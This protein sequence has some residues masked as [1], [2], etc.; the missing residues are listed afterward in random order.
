MNTKE[1][2]KQI[3]EFVG[4]QENIKNIMHCMTRLRIN[5]Y[6]NNKV[7]SEKLESLKDVLKVQF[8]NDQL[9]IIIGPQVAQLYQ[10]IEQEF[11]FSDN[12][13]D[14]EEKQGII[15]RFLNV[16]SSVFVPVIPAIASAGMLKAIIALIKAFEIIPQ[17]NDAFIIFNMMADVAF[18]F[19]PILLAS[20]ASKIFNTNRTISIVLASTL[21]HPTFIG[22]VADTEA[23]LSI[24]GLPVP[25]IN[26]AS[27][28]V[29]II[30]S[31]WIMSY[32]YHY[33]DKWMPNALKV[34]FTPT[35]TLLIMVPLMLV[36]LGPL[37]N[38]VGVIISYT[39]GT[40]FSFNRFI[41]GF[42]LSFIRPLLVIT[43]MHQAFTPVIFQNLAERGSDFLL[44]TMMMS[45]MGQ[46]G[47]VAAMIFKTRN[48]EKKTIATSASVSAILG[49]T[50]PALYTVLIY[51][52]KALLSA[53]IGGAIGG[54]FIS[55]TGFELP[56][57]ASSSI[58][59]LPIYLQVNIPN[60]IIAFLIS[61][62][63]AFIITFL[64]VRCEN[65][66]RVEK[67]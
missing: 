29:P 23:S 36:V 15:K 31:V 67:N 65:D 62:I 46:F 42:I 66:E 44:P 41:G 35:I 45:T 54:A 64:T 47:A 14:G 59:S 48:K 11:N 2:G 38:Y 16:L 43:G 22:L 27:S 33:V 58:V 18:Y 12:N 51:N 53:C 8:Q 37:G 34:I 19:L 61:M 32:V 30:L 55:M 56:A 39:V 7:E 28:V 17:D 9:Q 40:L 4:G 24:F 3:V 10:S 1:L 52:R 20:S 49:I 6:D 25:L 13:G 50:E 57:F 63:S 60:V 26:Y 5:L 21:I